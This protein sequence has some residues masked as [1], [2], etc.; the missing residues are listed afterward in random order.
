MRQHSPEVKTSELALAKVLNFI[1]AVVPALL[2]FC[3]FGCAKDKDPYIGKPANFIYAKGHDYLQKNDSSDAVTAFE[4]LNSQYPFESY[5][6]QGNLELIYAYYKKDDPTLALATA[7]RY[8]KLYP[9]DPNDAYA[10]YLSGVIDFENGRGILQ[11][12]FHYN[13]AEHNVS[14]YD[15]AF[16]T[17]NIVTSRYPKSPYAMDARRR[18]M[19]LDNTEAQYELN[20][21]QFYYDRGAYVGALNRAKNVIT[22]FPNTPSVIPALVLSEQAYL[23]LDLP[24]LAETMHQV[25]VSN[26]AN[27]P[28]I[29]LPIPINSKVSSP[30]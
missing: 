27:N 8:L 2:C 4:S 16:K 23:A 12:Y 25:A 15:L 9:N 3:L 6:K 26:I 10:Y 1:P 11:T 30:N 29:T 5:S 28:N 13:M 22:Q 7:E 24:E 18:M 17:L 14:N 20:I 19:Y 21:A